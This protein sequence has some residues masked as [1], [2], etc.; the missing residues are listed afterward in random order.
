MMLVAV[1]CCF[2]IANSFKLLPDFIHSVILT[3]DFRVLF[4]D[5]RQHFPNLN[6]KPTVFRRLD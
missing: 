1:C 4:V 5:F 2:T 3:I 6:H